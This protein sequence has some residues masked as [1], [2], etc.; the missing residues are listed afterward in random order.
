MITRKAGPALAVG[1]AIVIKPASETPLSALALAELAA[2]AGL[3]HG[4]LNVVA[5]SS[6]EIGPVITGAHRE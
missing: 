4:L 1:C 6:R 5:G 2:R 3:P